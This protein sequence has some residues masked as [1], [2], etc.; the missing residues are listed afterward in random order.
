M[1][2]ATAHK[3]GGSHGLPPIGVQNYRPFFR[4][5]A[6]ALRA[7]RIRAQVDAIGDAVAIAVQGSE[8]VRDGE[9]GVARR[10]RTL[11]DQ[12]A[13]TVEHRGG[14]QFLGVDRYCSVMASTSPKFCG[15]E[16]LSPPSVV[17]ARSLLPLNWVS[18][19]MSTWSL[20]PKLAPFLVNS[21]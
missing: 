13:G 5:A 2:S 11:L 9:R 8:L 21:L 6:V 12:I 14:V 17:G 1:W 18:T 7:R 16:Q 20:V 19:Q 15:L 4:I 3:K 10:I